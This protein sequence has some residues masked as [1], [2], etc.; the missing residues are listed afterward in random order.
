LSGGHTA[1]GWLTYE[2]PAVGRVLLGYG[3][4]A[5]LGEPPLF[6]VIVRET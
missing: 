4:N 6:E 1:E 2:V 3:G 5:F